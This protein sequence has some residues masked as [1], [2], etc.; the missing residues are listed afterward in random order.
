MTSKKNPEPPSPKEDTIWIRLGTLNDLPDILR[1][2]EDLVLFDH[3]FDPTLELTWSQSD[4]GMAFFRSRLTSAAG[5]V[6]VAQRR[7]GGLVAYLAASVVQAADY[8]R[9]GPM[10]EVDCLFVEPEVRGKGVGQ[11]LL[12]RFREWAEENGLHRVRVVVSAENGDAIRF[13]RREGFSPYD[14]V[15]E[16]GEIVPPQRTR[17]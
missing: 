7:E 17:L 10:A 9:I 3:R 13:Y 6:L 12:R 1:M 14:L 11:N 16:G 8:R 5:V 15:L 2:D 4:A